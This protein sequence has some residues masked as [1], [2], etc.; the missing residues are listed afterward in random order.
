MLCAVLYRWRNSSTDGEARRVR[1]LFLA[2]TPP[3]GL[4]I[5]AHYAF[6]RG[7][8]I[9]LVDAGSVAAIYEGA[10]PFM[11]ALDFEIEPVLNVIEAISISM[12]VDDWAEQV[13]PPGTNEPAP[14]SDRS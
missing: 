6:A 5:R 2:W 13:A 8:G 14:T 4:E 3:R 1:Q 12:D 7:G 9:V 11:S 10:A